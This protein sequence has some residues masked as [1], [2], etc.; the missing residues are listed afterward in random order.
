M[1]TDKNTASEITL[2]G[3]QYMLHGFPVLGIPDDERAVKYFSLNPFLPNAQNRCPIEC[4]YCVCHQD[5]D[6]HHYPQNFQD[7]LAPID[8]LDILLDRIFATQEGQKGFPISLC[9]YSD[10]FIPAHRERVLSILD[11]L[12]ERKAANIVYITTKVHP[13]QSFLERL[14]TTLEQ[15]HSL[16]VTVFVSLPP[17]KPGYEQASIQSRVQLL[18]DLVKL[19]IPCCWYLRPLVE[20]WFDEALM[21]QLARTLLPHISHHVILS[22]LVMSEEIEASLL[23]QELIVPEWDRTQPGRKEY[24]SLEFESKLRSILSTVASE[25]NTSLGPVMG[26]RLCGTN[27][28]HAYGCLICAKQNRYCQLYQLHHYGETIAA[29]DNQRLKTLLKQDP[30]KVGS[31]LQREPSTEECR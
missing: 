10:P 8:L 7:V 9:D 14:K 31:S 12:I 1:N 13:G 28:N 16:R 22:G 19:G 11:A 2:Q 5:R 17:L 26:H 20:Q 3:S 21:W 6:W 27:G 23:K 18:Q 29:E 15:P 24:L 25:Q 30:L 4:A